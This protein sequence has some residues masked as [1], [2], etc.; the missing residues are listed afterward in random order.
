MVQNDERQKDCCTKGTE[1]IYRT[2]AKMVS[3]PAGHD[4][5][6]NHGDIG[7]N[8]VAGHRLEVKMQFLFQV[9]RHPVAHTVVTK[10]EET[11]GQRPEDEHATIRR[12]AE[13]L[14]H[15]AFFGHL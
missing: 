1:S 2:T 15:G 14:L 8:H 4:L 9:G 12:V 13:D 6:Q 5:A 3:H 7:A 11:S 10:L